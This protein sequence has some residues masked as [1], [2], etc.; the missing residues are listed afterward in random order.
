[1][2]KSQTDYSTSTL[3]ITIKTEALRR[4]YLPIIGILPTPI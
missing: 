2:C 3:C 4:K 1:M